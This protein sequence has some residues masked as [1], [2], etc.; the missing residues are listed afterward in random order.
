[1]IAATGFD[2]ASP[3]LL[4]LTIDQGIAK[5]AYTPLILYTVL[6]ALAALL[7]GVTNYAQSYLQEYV[8][9]R[10]VFDLR[11][12]LYN[13]L[14]HLPF[15][16]FNKAQT[17]Q[18]MSRLTGDVESIKNFLGFGLMLVV[19]GLFA[20][21]GT[22][23]IMLTM[24]WKQ[25]LVLLC[26]SPFLIAVVRR[27]NKKIKPAWQMIRE[28]MGRMTTVLQENLTG[29]RVVRAFAS[30][31]AEKVKFRDRNQDNLTQNI[32]RANIEASSSPFMDFFGNAS[33]V[34]L[35]WYGG[36]QIMG[37]HMTIGTLMAFQWYAFGLSWPIRMLGSLANMGQQAMAAAPRVFT[38][39]DEPIAIRSPELGGHRPAQING[40]VHIDNVSFHFGDKQPILTD[41][42]MEA[43]PGQVI[44]LLGGTGSGK[45]TL[46]SLLPRFYDATDGCITI[47]GTDIRDFDL[48][49]LRRNIGSVPQDTFLF[50]A[51]IRENIAYGRPEA[52]LEEVE[53]AAKR[54]QAHEFIMM[55]KDGYDTIIG[56]RGVGLSGGQ[57]QR[58]AL[59]RA[60]LFDPPILILDE[61]TASVDT[62]TEHA[63]QQALIEV[64]KN[65][66]TFV[67]AQRL[68]TIK[69]A[70]LIYVLGDGKVVQTGT[71]TDLMAQDGFYRQLYDL[72][73]RVQEENDDREPVALGGIR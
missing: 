14:Q 11:S 24:N 21:L 70:S 25:T 36:R 72:Q 7:R 40:N 29:V 62:E 43:K 65:R 1:M 49:Y 67:I 38:I 56:E 54:A 57:K 10:V 4:K 59:A 47:D 42:S 3:Y 73:F 69:T 52:T 34:L 41:V 8:G 9:E 15:S 23:V 30:E 60:I 22:L 58:V 45:S 68:S 53:T 50:S 63:I 6:L 39:L 20:L 55:M 71:H 12:Q 32:D 28:Q 51:T 44:A 31:N 5:H 61:A 26:L 27:Y 66:T 19:S 33:I 64:M 48:E 18:L 37:G 46:V 16:Y 13:H 17:G 2:L 35:I